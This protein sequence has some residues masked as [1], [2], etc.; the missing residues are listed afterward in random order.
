MVVFPM[1][2]CVTD[3]KIERLPAVSRKGYDLLVAAINAIGWDAL[4]DVRASV[5]LMKVTAAALF[6]ECLD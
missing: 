2:H 1:V 3:G 6:V 4:L 5:F